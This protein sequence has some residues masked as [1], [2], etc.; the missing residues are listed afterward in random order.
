MS[1]QAQI[2]ANQA[3]SQHSTGPKTNAGKAIS[4]KNNF[5]HGLTGPFVV[6]GWENQEDFRKLKNELLTEH[7]PATLTEELLVRDMAQS[8][9]LRRRAVKLQDMCFRP[10]VPLAD[11]P[12]EL[13]LY[14]RYQTTHD[15]AFYKALNELQKLRAEKRKQENG[16][17]SQGRKA[18][19]EAR[20]KSNDQRREAH[21][22]RR[23]NEETRRQELH[24]A[25]V[26][27]AEAQA[28]RHETETAIA[29]ALKMPR[30][31]P[32]AGDHALEQAA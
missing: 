17:V 19:E 9:W 16:F 4:S 29:Q 32:S 25:R 18:A 7:Q 22:K 3:N 21:E 10:D 30:T 1:T 5:R 13:A 2:I 23:E 24:Q 28:R 14:L 20:R 15:R 6:L 12:K 26:W 8:H 31:T 27:L 11:Q